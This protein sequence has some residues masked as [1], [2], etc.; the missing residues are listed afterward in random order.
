MKKFFSLLVAAIL[1]GCGGGDG[2]GGVGIL[3]GGGV[4]GGDTT[5]EALTGTY[6]LT[7]IRFEYSNGLIATEKDLAPWSG[8][9][10]IG[11]TELDI[12]FAILGVTTQAGGPY[13]ATWSSN[14]SGYIS[15]GS[16][17]I[18]FTLSGGTLTLIFANLDVDVGVTADAFLIY[19]KVSNNHTNKSVERES[20]RTN[21]LN[22]TGSIKQLM[23][24]LIK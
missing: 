14:T 22:V 9:A 16:D 12:Q 13:S 20:L 5:Q 11:N 24:S 6:T 3:G 4:L 10:D 17:T 2:G 18:D 8:F 21:N 15:D 23:K 19:Q 7:G 1:V